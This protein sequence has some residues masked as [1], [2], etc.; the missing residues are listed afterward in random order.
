MTFFVQVTVPVSFTV[1]EVGMVV[2]SVTVLVTV[3]VTVPVPE[4]GMVVV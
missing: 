3:Q 2:V 1:S 4:V